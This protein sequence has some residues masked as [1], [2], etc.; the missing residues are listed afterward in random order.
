[1]SPLAIDFIR[2]LLTRD[3]KSR[4]G[5]GPHGFQRLLAH[6]WFAD[7][8]WNQLESKQAQPPF[9]PDVITYKINFIHTGA[10]I[11]IRTKGPILIRH[12]N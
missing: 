10:N 4:I 12:M 6:P 9:A 1:V 3:I 8:P 11:L 7:I 5:V 2:C